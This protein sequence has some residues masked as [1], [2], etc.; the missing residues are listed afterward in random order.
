ME[1]ARQDEKKRQQ[2][3]RN[4]HILVARKLQRVVLRFWKG[5]RPNVVK[6]TSNGDSPTNSGMYS[7]GAFV[8]LFTHHKNDAESDADNDLEP[9]VNLDAK[10]DRAMFAEV[11]TNPDV[12]K[13][14]QELQISVSDHMNLFEALDADDS[15]SLDVDELI[16]G[17][18]KLRGTA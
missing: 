9:E 4:E 14:L 17:L 11:I 6:K 5:Q 16:K 7:W 3:Q 18:M 1:A 15:G 8:R 13:M 2:L 10:I 12:E